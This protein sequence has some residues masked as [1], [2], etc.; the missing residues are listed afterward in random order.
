MGGASGAGAGVDAGAGAGVAAVVLG[1]RRRFEGR[2]VEGRSPPAGAQ[3]GLGHR[4]HGRVVVDRD[5]LQTGAVPFVEVADDLDGADRVQSHLGEGPLVVDLLRPQIEDLHQGRDDVRAHLG[6]GGPGDGLRRGLPRRRH[7]GLG[8]ERGAGSPRRGVPRPPERRHAGE[9][10]P[11]PVAG[12]A[13]EHLLVHPDLAPDHLVQPGQHPAGQFPLETA[14]GSL[15]PGGE[16]AG[17]VQRRRQHLTA[18]QDRHHGTVAVQF[19]AGHGPAREHHLVREGRA[20]P[21][22]QD[23]GGPHAG[24]EA[25]RDEVGTVDALLGQQHH[26]GVQPEGQAASGG[27]PVDRGD[28]GAVAAQ[29]PLV[30]EG[31]VGE[32]S[33]AVGQCLQCLGGAAHAEHAVGARDDDRFD[34]RAHRDRVEGR[35][36]V[37]QQPLGEHG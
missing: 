2:A 24:G 18:R 9:V 33:L 25:V 22:F 36:Q 34:V 1:P 23:V 20:E 37:A 4:R 31:L 32:A 21:A 3:E 29:Q 6:L 19:G 10:T 13:A 7:R 30:H 14:Y 11:D 26:V 28:H 16:R 27:V 8:W 5:G 15:R 17:A 35:A 12:A